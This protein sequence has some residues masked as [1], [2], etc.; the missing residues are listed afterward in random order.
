VE[1]Q[2][3]VRELDERGIKL[4]TISY[5]SQDI[6]RGFTE[7]NDITFT[8]LSD[9]E[10][11]VIERFDLLNPVPEWVGIDG[12]VTP[13]NREA[14]E[15]FVSVVGPNPEWAG[16]AFPGTFILDS[17]GMVL[18]RHFQDFYIERNTIASVLVRLGEDIDP[19]EATEVSTPQFDLTT[20]S[21]NPALA[22]GN[23]FTLVLDFEPG[24][25]MHI[26]APGAADYRVV[27]LDIEPMPYLDIMPMAYPE[28]ESYYFEP[29]DE[30]V[31]VYLEPFTLLQ[32]VILKGDLESQGSLRGQESLTINGTLEYQACDENVCYSP[33]S[34]P[35]SWTMELRPL[36]FR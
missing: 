30:T 33:G 34:V 18:E 12:G 36:V 10:S 1:L 9:T 13:E 11:E 29:F 20:Y 7:R 4:V 17:D 31:P 6:L 19:V 24:E 3:D 22:V 8:M 5:E 21:T 14:V 26:Y 32:E 25:D 2:R 35:L 27:A 23:R 15:T 16:I 28:S